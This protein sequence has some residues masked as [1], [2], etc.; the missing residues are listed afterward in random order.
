MRETTQSEIEIG[1]ISFEL[2]EKVTM[3]KSEGL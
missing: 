3:N 1:D 2:M